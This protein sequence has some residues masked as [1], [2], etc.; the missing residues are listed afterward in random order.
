MKD[1]Y[2]RIINYMRISVTDRCNLRCAYCMPDEGIE[3]IGHDHILSF[4][5]IER[6]VKAS[7]DLGIKKFRITGG[8][9][10]VRKGIV[11]LVRKISQID[12]VEELAMTTNGILLSKYAEDLKKA[13][14][15]RVNISLDSLNHTKYNKI[16]RGGD[17][18]EAF[19]GINAAVNAGLTPVKIN[20]V[21]MKGFNDNEIIDFVQLTYQHPYEIRF[22][23]LMPVGHANAEQY[24][25]ITVDE[26]KEKLP[27][28]RPANQNEGVAEIFK[29]PGAKGT[30]GFISP[31]SRHFCGDC[32]KIR[33]TA[34]GKLKPCLLSNAEID[35]NEVLNQGNDEKLKD[36][37][38]DV[39]LNKDEK[40]HLDEGAAPIERDMN[41]IGG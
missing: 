12:G 16:T 18:N 39:I 33:L 22:I 13:G 3:N 31:L 17:L 38:K 10:L 4:E 32:N 24:G 37:I 40:H 15:D 29:Y 14:L 26:I 36:V 7:V 28:L 34:D 5:N 11:E 25:V 27:A 30:L 2:G 41:K 19:A 21:A 1:N 6:I 20:V 9:P 8:E 35:L 23:E